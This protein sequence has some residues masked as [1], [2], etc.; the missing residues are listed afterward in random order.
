MSL[1]TIHKTERLV[2][3]PKKGRPSDGCYRNGARREIAALRQSFV[4]KSIA[5]IFSNAV[6]LCNSHDLV[7][8]HETERLTQAPKKGRPSDVLFLAQKTRFELV[9]RF[10]HTTPLAGEPL[11]PLGYFCNS[12]ITFFLFKSYTTIPHFFR[13]VKAFCPKNTKKF[14]FLFFPLFFARCKSFLKKYFQILDGFFAIVYNK[15]VEKIKNYG[16]YAL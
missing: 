4:A 12:S 9:L 10:S 2:S 7:I 11:E 6:H 14:L 3:T 13:I 16:A 15:A 8:I 5:R 1:V